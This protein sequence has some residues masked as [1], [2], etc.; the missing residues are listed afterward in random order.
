M[1]LFSRAGDTLVL[2]ARAKPIPCPLCATA[3]SLE[4]RMASLLTSIAGNN[5]CVTQFAI[6]KQ[7]QLNYRPDDNQ[8]RRLLFKAHVMAVVLITVQAA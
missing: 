7:I 3:K 6:L 1:Q 4:F 5:R 2:L 8:A